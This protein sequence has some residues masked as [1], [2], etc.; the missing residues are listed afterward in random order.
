M[1]FGGTLFNP[2]Q[3]LKPWP[4]EVQI[5]ALPLTSCVN[6]GNSPYLL[7]CCSPIICEFYL[8]LK[9]IVR[10]KLDNFCKVFEHSAWHSVTAPTLEAIGHYL[11]SIRSFI[12]LRLLYDFST[13]LPLKYWFSQSSFVDMCSSA[14]GSSSGYMYVGRGCR[15]LIYSRALT[16]NPF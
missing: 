15:E 4:L 14:M 11:P 12:S 9:L 16:S 2:L 8:L 13:P 5:L 10:S 7:M 1:N 3:W 6:L